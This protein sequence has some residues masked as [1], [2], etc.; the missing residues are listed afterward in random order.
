MAVTAPAPTIDDGSGADLTEVHRAHVAGRFPSLALL[1]MAATA[2]WL[3]ILLWAGDV[4]FPAALATVAAQVLVLGPAAVVCGRRPTSRLIVP[5]AVAAFVLVGWSWIA[6]F[7]FSGA[8]G[9]ILGYVLFVMFAGAAMGTA[10]GIGPQLVLQACV[11]AGWLVAVPLILKRLS[12]SE[13][14]MVAGFGFTMATVIAAW[15]AETFRVEQRRRIQ[16]ARLADQ[17][18]ASRDA[19]RDLYENARDFI[20]IADLKG[21]LVYVNEAVARL[22]DRPVEEIVGQTIA[23]LLTDHPANPPRV[24]WRPGVARVRAGERLPPMIVQVRSASGPIWV[25]T[26][27]SPVRDAD[28]QVTGLQATSRDV[29]ERLKA[30]EALRESEARYR[31]LVDELRASEEK[32]RLLAQRQVTI[33]ED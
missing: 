21:T 17:L 22:H 1:N 24:D 14:V 12:P 7:A 16:E 28:G 18:R 25:E 29:T 10:W 2:L 23:D 26:V 8:S 4:S 9:I 31:S 27:I 19:F 6:L 3:P 33:R 11:I 13:R 30:E 20:W 32:L 15:A 5:V